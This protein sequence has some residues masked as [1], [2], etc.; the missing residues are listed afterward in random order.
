M[1]FKTY[2]LL[3]QNARNLKYIKW[4]NS[5][6][7]RKLADSKLQTKYFLKEK[8]IPVPETLAVLKKHEEITN[9]LIEKLEPPFVIKPNAGFGWKWIIVVNSLDS[10]GKFITNTWKV[11][12][13]KD[14]QVHLLSILDGFF[15]LSGSRDRVI[16]EKKIE[17]DNQ[18]HILWKYWL[19]DIRIIVFN[20]VP[21]MAMLRIPTEKSWW[22]ANLHSWACAAWIDIWS[23]KLTYITQ[24]WKIVKSVP[25][26]WDI[27]WLVLPNW[28]KM[29]E[30]AVSVQKETW[31]WYLGCDIVMDEKDWPL[32]L[33]INIRP[34]LE[35]QVA[36][37]ARLKDRLERVE[38]IHVNSVEKW[39]RLWKDL[40]S[41][42]IDEKIKNLSGK[43]VLWQREYI[44]LNYKE[45]KYKY[46]TEINTG[47]NSS[48][49]DKWFLENILKID[50]E[51]LENKK[52][53]ITTDVFG[54]EKNI[55]FSI[56]DLWSVNMILGLNSLRWFL[57]DP[58]KYKKWELPFSKDEEYAKT[59]NSA[60]NKNYKKQLIKLDEELI[61]IDRKLLILKNITPINLTEE[62]KKFIESKWEY[63][64]EFEYKE[65]NLD[66]KELQ[67]QI[68]KIEIPDIPLSGIYSRKKE[69]VLNKINFLKAVSTWNNEKQSKYSN[70]L[71]WD[72]IEDNV[73]FSKEE[74]VNRK[75]AKPEKDL[76]VFEEIKQYINKFNHIYWINIKLKKWN[77]ASRFVMWWDTL[78]YKDWA[79]V[80]KK[81]MRSI[82]AHEIEWHYLRR[83]NGKNLDYKIFSS[84]TARYIEIDEWIAVYNQNRF[85][86]NSDFKYYWIY[87]WYYLLNYAEKHSY[88]ELLEKLL[89]FYKYDLW[90]VFDRIV[91][92]KRWFTKASDDWVFYKD[93]VYLN[94][95]LKIN[96]F[97]EQGWSL[98]ELYLWKMWIEDLKELKES[99]F[100][101]LK[102]NENKIP[103]FL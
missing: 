94:W 39:V 52:I 67:K 12:S 21:V 87:E 38:W 80:G 27:R 97:I 6:M 1:F 92:I 73:L 5:K 62:K 96:K 14:I 37:L 41:W 101:K 17:I 11:F 84:W 2:G 29:L 77:K 44:T 18:V 49:I 19:P 91:R 71:F 15:S 46:L 79:T 25:W 48:F 93:V 64:P 24:H 69:E 61:K 22:K 30:M 66:F 23:G 50:V 70:L 10:S 43:K 16:I 88:K 58:F 33:E 59:I 35:V 72:I 78:Y 63:I 74:L 4:F 7:A 98:K 53:R 28:N 90:K 65:I 42:D 31:I 83:L 82:I 57:I 95:F 13:K 47:Q 99:Y 34:G 103:F 8:G 76:L 9:D 55:N 40:F 45:K 102:F 56:K 81:E 54:I 60:L 20:M 68:E 36:N 51:K 32:L 75:N 100:M 85:L 26:I 89:E 3:G 86:S